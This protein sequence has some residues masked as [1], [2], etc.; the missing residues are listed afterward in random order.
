MLRLPKALIAVVALAA[1]GADNIYAPQAVVDRA[2]YVDTTDPPYVTLFTVINNENDAGA[3][4]SLL[5]NGSQRVLFDPAGTWF[6]PASPEQHDVHFGIT[7]GVLRFYIDYHARLSYRVFEQTLPVSRATAD[8]LIAAA[9]AHGAADK[10]FCSISVAQVLDQLPQFDGT[11]HP[12][13]FPNRLSKEFGRLAGVSDVVIYD[14]DSNDHKAMLLGN[15]TGSEAANARM[16]TVGGTS[17][18]PH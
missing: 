10:G 13:F 4:S 3:H 6:S 1:C 2:R 15:A 5:I 18:I 7:D 12:T 14:K 16:A 17:V 9:E 11:I 8:A